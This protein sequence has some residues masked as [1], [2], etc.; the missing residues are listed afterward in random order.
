MVNTLSGKGRRLFS[1]AV[2]MLTG[3]G[4]SLTASYRVR[5]PAR[6]PALV[7]EAIDRGSRLIIIG[8]GDGTIS[9]LV[10]Y[11]AYKDI[12]FGLLPLGT[13]NSFARSLGLPLAL[14]GAADVIVNGKVADIDLGRVNDDYFANMASIGFTADLAKS[15][16]Y[17]LKRIIG[18]V[19]Y[20]VNGI[21]QFFTTRKFRCDLVLDNISRTVETHLVVVANGSFFGITDM[22]PEARIESRHLFVLTMDMMSRWD[23][24]RL[25]INFLR[26]KHKRL[27]GI[28]YFTTNRIT[29]H[30]DPPREI[31]MDGEAK[32]RTPATISLAPQALKVMVPLHFEERP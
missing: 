20:A 30:T 29:I 18:N 1:D 31:D 6:F 5:D 25:W 2:D 22:S 7:R 16:P 32:A 14:E 8:G 12:V 24:L 27:E 3:R 23:L 26:R 19:A 13:A 17:R 15:T 10:D 28:L 4:I 11:F 9:S 21:R